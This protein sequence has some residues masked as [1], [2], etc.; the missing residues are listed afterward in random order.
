[1]NACTGFNNVPLIRLELMRSMKASRI[2]RF[3]WVIFPS[4]LTDVFTGM[5]LA[6]IFA[7]TAC[8]GIEFVASNA[9]LGNRISYYTAYYQTEYAFACIFLVGAIGLVLYGLAA[10]L[11]RVLIPF[12]SL[13]WR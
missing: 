1:M 2:Q 11:E 7:T 10:A 5:R 4:G 3:L 6:A 8:V 9:G 12:N 13:K